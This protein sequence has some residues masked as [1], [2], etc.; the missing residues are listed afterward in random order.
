MCTEIVMQSWIPRATTTTAASAAVSVMSRATVTGPSRQ[1]G[2]TPSR[3]TPS[4][5]RSVACTEWA[6]CWRRRT[7]RPMTRIR[8]W[9]RSGI[10]SITGAAPRM[11]GPR[12]R[13]VVCWIPPG[14][15]SSS[16]GRMRATPEGRSI[17]MPI[18]QRAFGTG[19][20][21]GGCHSL[22]RQP[23]RS[24]PDRPLVKTTDTRVLADSALETSIN[25]TPRGIIT[26][27]ACTRQELA[28]SWWRNANSN[29]VPAAT[30][31]HPVG[32]PSYTPT[33]IRPARSPTRSRSGPWRRSAWALPTAGSSQY[34]EFPL[35]RRSCLTWYIR[36]R[37]WDTLPTIVPRRFRRNEEIDGWIMS[38]GS[39]FA[40]E[41]LR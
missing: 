30:S 3:T 26:V 12:R 31:R 8:T 23:T 33:G 39:N 25:R 22:D 16:V 21:I 35:R 37:K 2:L 14:V 20:G 7:T 40:C 6:R 28:A 18:V 9:S 29:T 13:E 41:F 19:I 1:S 11:T 32:P 27:P 34:V 4:A 17:A 36:R 5:D 10:I 24:S 38:C 15:E